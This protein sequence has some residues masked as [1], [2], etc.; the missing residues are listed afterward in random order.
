MIPARFSRFNC[1]FPVFAAFF[2]L[3]FFLLNCKQQL[4]VKKR[5]K[6]G[7]CVEEEIGCLTL[8][9]PTRLNYLDCP[10]NCVMRDPV[11]FGRKDQTEQG[12][13]RQTP[14]NENMDVDHWIS[15]FMQKTPLLPTHLI[16]LLCN[17][18][19]EI[20]V[21]EPNIRTITSPVCFVG[22]IHG[23]FHDLKEMFRIGGTPPSTNYCF[24]GDYVDRG[25]HSIE[26]M[27]LLLLLKVRWPDRVTLI[28]G[29]HESRCVTTTYG[30]YAECVRKYPLNPGI[31]YNAFTDVFDY[32]PLSVK[33]DPSSLIGL[34]GGIGPNSMT[35]DQIRIVDRF[36]EIPHEGTMADIVWS[37]PSGNP[38]DLHH[39]FSVS[40]RGAGY[41]FGPNASRKFCHLN[42]VRGLVR[43]HQLC[44]KGYQILHDDLVTTV[45]SA[46]NYLYRSGNL[47]SIMHVDEYERTIIT[48]GACPV[49]QEEETRWGTVDVDDIM[50]LKIKYGPNPPGLPKRSKSLDSE[51]LNDW[52]WERDSPVW[53]KDGN[54]QYFL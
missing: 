33:L 13:T 17:K 18:S 11:C 3:V 12:N 38:F 52:T 54:P 49:A 15:Q 28:R 36:R 46:P 25:H 5:E 31:V 2:R 7:V 4:C 32:L 39:D 47:A 43:A 37:D 30:F 53:N 8:R 27:S 6:D 29:N 40:E 21:K 51:T 44:L 10:S 22:D 16:P 35:L 45:W 19:K 26:T 42:N 23:Q 14:K 24:L 48:Y 50:A 34:H 41:L 9:L 1:H 20:L